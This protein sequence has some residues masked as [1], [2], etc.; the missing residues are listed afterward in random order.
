M[1]VRY[2]GRCFG[3]DDNLLYPAVGVDDSGG[4]TVQDSGLVGF[5]C[6]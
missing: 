3:N 2:F 4:V 5:R 6:I 1:L